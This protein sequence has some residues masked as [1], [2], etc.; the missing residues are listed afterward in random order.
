MR[1]HL[2]R[3][4]VARE[5]QHRRPEERVK[6]ED[7]L[8]DEVVELGGRVLAPEL[9]EVEPEPVAQVAKAAH[10][11]DRRVEPDVEVLA[12]RARDL[13]TE[14]RS[15]ARDVPVGELPGQ[16]FVEL[17]RRFGLQT[18]CL[19]RPFAQEFPAA[20]VTQPE[21][22]VLGL[23]PDR[24]RTRYGRVRIFEIGG[25]IGRSAHL[26]GIAVLVLRAA[27]G[28]LA[29]DEAVRQEHLLHRVV[30][31]LDGAHVDQARGRLQLPEDVLGV[32]ARLR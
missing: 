12:R 10:V 28:T 11:S 6:V 31:L 20:R 1:E 29:L 18:P 15:V 9:I 17:V 4:P 30:E 23:L 22:I 25:S 21:E 13:E 3:R 19:A 8:A 27:L 32:R 26:A 24:R 16:P 7:V 14:V 2:R 5:L